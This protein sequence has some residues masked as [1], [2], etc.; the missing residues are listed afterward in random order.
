MY[1]F[2]INEEVL[3]RRILRMIFSI[4]L[5]FKNGQDR[6]S[7]LRRELLCEKKRLQPISLEYAHCLLGFS[8]TLEKAG[9]EAFTLRAK[10]IDP[11]RSILS[12]QVHRRRSGAKMQILYM[13]NSGIEVS[14]T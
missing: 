3:G 4:K 1:V 6:I 10:G 14:L 5:N 2:Q 8:W 13:A 12:C 9:A 7:N 11:S